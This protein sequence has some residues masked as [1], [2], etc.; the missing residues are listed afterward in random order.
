MFYSYNTEPQACNLVIWGLPWAN[1]YLYLK[2]QFQ[3]LL[4]LKKLKSEI[5]TVG[6]LIEE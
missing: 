4:F 3:Q 1:F 2:K 5:G 6:I